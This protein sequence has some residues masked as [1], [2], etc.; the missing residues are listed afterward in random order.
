MLVKD[1]KT[2][3]DLD[4]KINTLIEQLNTLFDRRQKLVNNKSSLTQTRRK[5]KTSS[6]INLDNIDLRDIDLRLT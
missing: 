5:S 2:I 6:S 3:N 1:M 4:Q